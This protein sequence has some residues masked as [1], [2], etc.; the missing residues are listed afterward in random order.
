MH[1]A[2]LDGNHPSYRCLDPRSTTLLTFLDDPFST[3]YSTFL[4]FI[5]IAFAT[6]LL[7]CLLRHHYTRSKRYSGS[8]RWCDQLRQ[9]GRAAGRHAGGAKDERASNHLGFDSLAN[10]KRSRSGS[11][12]VRNG[13]EISTSDWFGLQQDSGLHAELG[14]A[15]SCTFHTPR[16]GSML[17]RAFGHQGE[18]YDAQ[19][20]MEKN[21]TARE[22]HWLDPQL[23]KVRK[24]ESE[25]A[26]WPSWPVKLQQV[27]VGDVKESGIAK[28][29]LTLGRADGKGAPMD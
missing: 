4:F 6:V 1:S 25:R 23:G 19:I 26:K 22:P 28:R 18:H 15:E 14:H 7:I 16:T 29:R 13:S 3:P 2:S 9:G 11:D 5:T 10:E 21:R 12:R 27:V 20:L 17:S 24:E 8:C